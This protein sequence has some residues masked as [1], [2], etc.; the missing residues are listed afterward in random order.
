M[1][2]VRTSPSQ[3][4]LPKE[5]KH[6]REPQSTKEQSRLKYNVMVFNA[7]TMAALDECLNEIVDN[8]LSLDCIFC[9]QK[10]KEKKNKNAHLKKACKIVGS[11]R[12]ILK[13]EGQISI[14]LNPNV[15]TS[16][17]PCPSVPVIAAFSPAT[18]AS[19]TA[20]SA[21]AANSPATAALATAA[22]APAANS[23]ATAASAT[24]ASATAASASAAYQ[25]PSAAPAANSPDTAASTTAALAP[26]ANSPDTA[27][28]A[29]AASASAANSPAT[30]ALA[31]AAYQEP[32]AAPA[33]NSSDTAA[34]A[35]AAPAPADNSPDTAASATAGSVPAALAHP[36]L[37]TPA[38]VSNPCS[39]PTP[40][41][42][43][44]TV[45]VDPSTVF[46]F[47]AAENDYESELK[48][49]IYRELQRISSIKSS[50]L[51]EWLRKLDPNWLP[52]RKV[53]F[54]SEAFQTLRQ[55]AEAMKL[56]KNFAIKELEP[57]NRL[58][59]PGGPGFCR[60]A[61]I[62]QPY[63]SE[64]V[65]AF[66]KENA[67]SFV[68]ERR[69]ILEDIRETKALSAK[70]DEFQTHELYTISPD[71]STLRVW[72]LDDMT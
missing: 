34:L 18:A 1:A 5:E 24:A 22:P 64:E 41:A 46:C 29:T 27:A 38:H 52:S 72:G 61:R 48:R 56:Y 17:A 28:S 71:D 26:A 43:A 33:A 65:T 53:I 8:D 70:I 58:I 31:S 9:E 62:L 45:P 68:A 69:Q 6:A 44:N 36:V 63:D 55:E 60:N 12:T 11:K 10:F 20:A 23:P 30:A 37:D 15:P 14:S 51:P 67:K 25:E 21:S 2:F 47:G 40:T 32:S 35:T 42:P 39:A 57:L 13:W 50:D 66:L 16:A 49:K 4:D 59:G 19:Y 7:K 3:H 54:S